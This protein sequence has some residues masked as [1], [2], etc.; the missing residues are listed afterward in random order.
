MK[1]KSIPIN[2]AK[3]IAKEYGY[4]QVIII[5]RK[6]DQHVTTYGIDKIHCNVAA[7]IGD[8]IKYQI[9]KWN[10]RDDRLAKTVRSFAKLFASYAKRSHNDSH[11]LQ[12]SVDEM[13]LSLDQDETIAKMVKSETVLQTSTCRHS[14]MDEYST[15]KQ[16][17]DG[18][19]QCTVCE[20]VKGLYV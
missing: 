6:V 3:H 17:S 4:D 15:M 13:L 20:E 1:T 11:V 16:L 2:A 5:A 12:E 9:M 7:R 19:F 10:P 18:V 14:I 8:Y